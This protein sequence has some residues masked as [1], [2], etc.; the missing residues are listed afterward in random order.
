MREDVP[1]G[2]FSPS[3]FRALPAKGT[4]QGPRRP[5]E[6]GR[7]GARQRRPG[8]RRTVGDSKE[9]ARWALLLE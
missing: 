7:A 5:R 2:E 6:K 4:S 9:R 8:R 1:T 3:S